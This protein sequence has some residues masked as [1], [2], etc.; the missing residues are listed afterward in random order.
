METPKQ[1]RYAAVDWGN[2]SHA[3]CV[4]DEQGKEVDA[5]ETSHTP[6]GLIEMVERLRRCGPIFG[7]AV[8]TTRN[9]VVQKLLDASM[10]VYP[11]N[12]KLSHAWRE[13]WKVSSPKSDRTDAWVLAEGLRQNHTRLRAF[14]P[15]DPRTRELKML[16]ADECELIGQRT[17]LVNRLQAALREYYPHALGWFE[18]WTAPTAWDFVLTFSTPEALAGASR[19]KLFG[20]LK[21]HRIGLRAVWQERVEG[22]SKGCD[23]PGDPATTAA[24]SVLA[25]TLARSLRTLQAS[26]EEYRRRIEALYGEHPDHG[27][28]DSLPGAGPKI[29]PRLLGHFGTDRARFDSAESL[30]QLSGAAPVTQRSGRSK[31]VRMRH[32]CQRNFRNTLHQWTFLTLERSVWARAYYDSARRAGQSHALALRNLARKWLSILYR[33]WRDRQP[34]NEQRYLAAL[35]RHGSPLLRQIPN[36]QLFTTGG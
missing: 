12:P 8:E 11:V 1:L 16:C 15:D 2:A 33:M 21:A 18:D 9:L 31:N 7:V 14:L 28:F 22:R 20:F 23:W 30:E 6:E 32:C 34:Y 26:L 3:V 25:V 19:K 27:I 36:L 4:I 24:K 17:A 13:G 10:T 29:G 35:A 5:F